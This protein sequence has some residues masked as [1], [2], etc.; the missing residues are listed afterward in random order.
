MT[1]VL[2]SLALTAC[3][4]GAGGALLAAGRRAGD[5]LGET[6]VT[7]VAAEAGANLLS[8][9]VHNPGERSVLIGASVR[10]RSV[11]LRLEAGSFVS[12]PRRT[13]HPRL[14]AGRH[15]HVGVVEARETQ[16]VRVAVAD[17][18]PRRAELVIAIGETDR[19]RL[20]HRAVALPPNALVLTGDAPLASA[21]PW[22]TSAALSSRLPGL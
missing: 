14:L 20:I 3:V 21:A 9:T 6:I 2:L 16:R 8:F 1:E 4:L 12:V 18:T 19:L 5:R 15:A 22:R 13:A 10:R 17:D 7:D 11:R